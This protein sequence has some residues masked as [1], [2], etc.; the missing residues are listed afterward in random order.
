MK[1]EGFPITKLLPGS[2][3]ENESP[4]VTERKQ[5]AFDELPKG[6]FDSI[7]P[8]IRPTSLDFQGFPPRFIDLSPDS[9]EKEFLKWIE[10]EIDIDPKLIQ[11]NGSTEESIRLYQVLNYAYKKGKDFLKDVLRYSDEDLFIGPPSILKKEELFSLLNRTILAGGKTGLSRAPAY[12]RLVKVAMVTYETLKN[13]VASLKSSTLEFED[14]LITPISKIADRNAPFVLLKENEKGEKE[15]YGQDGTRGS[16]HSRYKDMNG[17]I[18]RFITR[19]ES[20]AKSALKD[21]IACRIASEEKP[22]IPPLIASPPSRW[23]FHF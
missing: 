20:N 18:L 16:I 17:A 3:P 11:E 8:S 23:F 22:D 9:K 6:S 21:G 7:S 14:S 15:F 10:K 2:K 13:D 5:D 4:K 1:N 12:C 19:P